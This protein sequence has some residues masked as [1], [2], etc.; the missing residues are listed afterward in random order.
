MVWR[1][2]CNCLCSVVAGYLNTR[3][4]LL[5]TR[6]LLCVSSAFSRRRI[7]KQKDTSRA[8]GDPRVVY[9]KLEYCHAWHERFV[10][11]ADLCRKRVKGE[12]YPCRLK[13][14]Q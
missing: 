2:L 5:S 8:A 9:K 3:I 1:P 10:L 14:R 11:R 4:F 12:N 13:S 6:I 7:H